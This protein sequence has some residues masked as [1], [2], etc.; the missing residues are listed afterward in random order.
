MGK[1]DLYTI[2]IACDGIPLSVQHDEHQTCSTCRRNHFFNLLPLSIGQDTE[3]ASASVGC[4]STLNGMPFPHVL[5]PTHTHTHTHTR[6]L[7]QV[8]LCDASP[9]DKDNLLLSIH[10]PTHASSVL[11]IGTGDVHAI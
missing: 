3:H 7:F 6:A 11:S 10:C 9:Q 1:L 8:A 5:N 4:L 2:E